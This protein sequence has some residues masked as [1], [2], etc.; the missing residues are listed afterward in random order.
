MLILNHFG[1]LLHPPDFYLRYA[2]IVY[3]IKV[4]I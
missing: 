1:R 2:S 3:N 4:A